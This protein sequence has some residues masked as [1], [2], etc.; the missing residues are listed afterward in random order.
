MQRGA[1]AHAERDGRERPAI[2]LVHVA[3]TLGN[4]LVSYLDI[5]GVAA[6]AAAW[7][8][9]AVVGFQ[10]A[11]HNLLLLVEKQFGHAVG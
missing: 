1:E 4:L 2:S 7:V 10:T 9:F 5:Q 3:A 8:G 11:T 6:S